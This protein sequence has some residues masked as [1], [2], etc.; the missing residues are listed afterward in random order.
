MLRIDMRGL[1]SRLGRESEPFAFG[2]KFQ[3]NFCSII[4]N[5]RCRGGEKLPKRAA[6]LAP[7]WRNLRPGFCRPRLGHELVRWFCFWVES[8]LVEARRFARVAALCGGS[9]HG[10]DTRRIG[11]LSPIC[12]R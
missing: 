9:S 8:L 2:R 4:Q 3:G 11:A 12:G 7:V 6:N 1:V 5:S 10:N